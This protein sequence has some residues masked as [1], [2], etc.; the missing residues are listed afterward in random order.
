[1]R[2]LEIFKPKTRGQN[3][4]LSEL[5][6]RHDKNAREIDALHQSLFNS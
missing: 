1:M 6:T 4:K 3:I 2:H 5:C